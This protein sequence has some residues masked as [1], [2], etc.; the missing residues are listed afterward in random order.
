MKKKVFTPQT[1][2]APGRTKY[3]FNAYLPEEL[4]T[5]GESHAATA[6][7]TK[8]KPNGITLSA[9]VEQLLR[10]KKASVERKAAIRAALRPASRG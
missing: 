3:R 10:K 7:K 8:R 4:V 5:W 1:K 2:Q 9:L 6:F